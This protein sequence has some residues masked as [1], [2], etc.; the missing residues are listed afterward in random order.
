M[1][2]VRPDAFHGRQGAVE[3]MI[4][5]AVL[6]HT[7]EGSHVP[8]VANYADLA[9]VA[10]GIGADRTGVAGGVVAAGLAEADGLAAFP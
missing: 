6:M 7:L 2:I 10:G 9:V 1:D 3:H 8:R 5:A 4:Q